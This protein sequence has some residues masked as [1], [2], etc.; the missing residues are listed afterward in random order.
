M[1][2]KQVIGPELQTTLHTET[3]LNVEQLHLLSVYE[4][5]RM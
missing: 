4:K 5:T 2:V 1:V 3:T